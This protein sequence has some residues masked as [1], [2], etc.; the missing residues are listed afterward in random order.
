MENPFLHLFARS[1]DCKRDRDAIIIKLHLDGISDIAISKLMA[2]AGLPLSRQSV[3]NVWRSQGLESV[4]I[5]PG[6]REKAVSMLSKGYASKEIAA[7]TGLSKSKI[8]QI[9]KEENLPVRFSK[10][11]FAIGSWV[12]YWKILKKVKGGWLCEDTRNGIQ[13]VL[14]T[15]NLFG[16]R[17]LGSKEQYAKRKHDRTVHNPENGCPKCGAIEINKDGVRTGY[18]MFKCKHCKHQFV[19]GTASHLDESR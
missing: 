4:R 10:R 14:Q 12:G 15:C 13:R 19:G 7:Q 8:Q 16:D 17:T 11:S 6:M 1:Q 18:Q 9:R 5:N 3:H 2:E